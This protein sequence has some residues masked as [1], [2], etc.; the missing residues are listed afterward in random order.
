MSAAIGI[1]HIAYHLP[2]HVEDVQ[3]WAKRTRQTASTLKRLEDAGVKHYYDARAHSALSLASHAVA[4]LIK[5]SHLA[6]QTLDCL[7]YVHTLQGSVAAPPHSLPNMLCDAFGFLRAESFSLAQ[8]H[9]AS[10]LAAL[11]VI[12][13]MFNARAELQRVLLVGAD[14]M[15]LEAARLMPAQGLLSDGAFAALIERAAPR[16]RLLAVT[17]H[18]SGEGWRGAL[19]SEATRTASLNFLI[20][21]ELIREAAKAAHCELTHITRIFPHHLDLPTW[22]RLL[23][24]L[25]M[26]EHRLFTE[27]FARI[28]HVTVSDAFINLANSEPLVANQLFLLFAQGIGGFSAAALFLH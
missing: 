26:P 16:N 5:S 19:A 8:Q 18:A 12:R 28:A 22:R 13:A 20:A 17:T 27:N 10:A 23:A 24:S 1:T 14:V 11:R 9:C 6:P 15:P 7:I 25:G 21:R 3:S 4:S 2:E